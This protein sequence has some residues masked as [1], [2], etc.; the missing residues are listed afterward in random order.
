MIQIIAIISKNIKK[1]I[2]LKGKLLLLLTENQVYK[3]TLHQFKN[4]PNPN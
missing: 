2:I 4:H 3:K 1:N